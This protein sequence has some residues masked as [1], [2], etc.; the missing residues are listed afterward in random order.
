MPGFASIA[1]RETGIRRGPPEPSRSGACNANFCKWLCAK[2]LQGFASRRQSRWHTDCY[3][4][5]R[6]KDARLAELRAVKQNSG[7]ACAGV[8]QV[9]NG[10]K[11][12]V[13][14]RVGGWDGLAWSNLRHTIFFSRRASQR[15]TEP[16]DHEN[17]GSCLGQKDA[18]TAWVGVPPSPPRPG[19]FRKSETGSQK[20]AM[21][22]RTALRSSLVSR[23]ACEPESAPSATLILRLASEPANGVRLADRTLQSDLR[24]RS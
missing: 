9:V 3:F 16:L 6:R 19:H 13:S 1:A 7:N 24:P 8:S 10:R 23:F 15:R 14:C 12:G 18:P 11:L 21:A 17:F 2:R 4:P 22:N 5:R 20:S